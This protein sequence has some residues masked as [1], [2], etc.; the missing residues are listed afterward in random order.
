[1]GVD[2][3]QLGKGV[4]IS[5]KVF[6]EKFKEEIEEMMKTK[7]DCHEIANLLIKKHIGNY[8]MSTLGHDAFQGRHGFVFDM[9]ENADQE[10]SCDMISSMM[11]DMQDK[12][13]S[14]FSLGC[15]DMMFIGAHYTISEVDL[16]YYIKAPEVIYSIASFIPNIM[17]YYPILN[18]MNMDEIFGQKPK[19]WTFTDDCC[20]CG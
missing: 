12:L 6:Y 17:K 2:S 9:F 3:I 5:V 4:I 7:T 14:K 1:M 16:S 8:E 19:I 15:G 20:C 10:E 11:Q 13:D 18:T